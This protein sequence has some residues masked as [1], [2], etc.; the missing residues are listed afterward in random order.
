MAVSAGVAPDNDINLPAPAVA[1]LEDGGGGEVV[2]VV[3]DAA[4]DDAAHEEAPAAASVWTPFAD[5]VFGFV[6]ADLEGWVCASHCQDKDS[7]PTVPKQPGASGRSRGVG[8]TARSGLELLCFRALANDTLASLHALSGLVVPRAACAEF[9]RHAN[10][11]LWGSAVSWE[12]TL[13]TPVA[14]PTSVR[15]VPA[16]VGAK[17]GGT[18]AG[19]RSMVAA[20]DKSS[21]LDLG[22]EA[23]VLPE[24]TRSKRSF[25]GQSGGGRRTASSTRSRKTPK[26]GKDDK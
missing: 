18:G 15:N 10:W 19:A 21:D 17:R 3:V 1:A 16:A 25:T 13:G 26:H 5:S 11:A 22:A 12:L 20:Q 4:V 23:P 6:P 9:A 7:W 8:V 14:F 2:G 24:R